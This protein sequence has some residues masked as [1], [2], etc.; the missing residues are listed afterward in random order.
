MCQFMKELVLW[1]DKQEPKHNLTSDERNLLSVAYKNVIGA[2]RASWRTLSGAKDPSS[3]SVDLVTL[4]TEQVEAELKEI[5]QEI[6]VRFLLLPFF[7]W[8]LTASSHVAG[9]AEQPSHQ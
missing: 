2:R 7:N 5:C 9:F 1:A 3:D 6:L 4:Y 8:D